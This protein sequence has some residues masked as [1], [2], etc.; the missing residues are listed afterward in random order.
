MSWE[1]EMEEDLIEKMPHNQ[2][3]ILDKITCL[4]PQIPE[5]SVK[6]HHTKNKTSLSL[7]V[8]SREW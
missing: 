2:T 5:K 7:A 3:L 8:V 4:L 6:C 1:A